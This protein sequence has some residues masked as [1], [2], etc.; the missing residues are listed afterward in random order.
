VHCHD[1]VEHVL[2]AILMAGRLL[3]ERRVQILKGPL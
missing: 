1:L 2:V 3:C